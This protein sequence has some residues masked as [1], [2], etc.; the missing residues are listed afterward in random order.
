MEF[1]RNPSVCLQ[2]T[3]CL[4]K[5]KA[6]RLA[7]PGKQLLRGATSS[8]VNFQVSAIGRASSMFDFFLPEFE[9]QTA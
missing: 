7:T 4:D 3:H 2:V 9:L 1:A 5:K 8:T 6:N